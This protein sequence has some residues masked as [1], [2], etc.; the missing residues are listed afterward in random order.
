MLL[1]AVWLNT[2][3]GLVDWGTRAKNQRQKTEVVGTRIA[4]G[5]PTSYWMLAVGR[6]VDQQREIELE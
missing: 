4:Q 6:W 1:G 5:N 2:S 3:R